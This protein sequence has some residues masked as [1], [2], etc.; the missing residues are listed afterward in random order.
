MKR[1]IAMI[2][3]F[4][5]SGYAIDINVF[6]NGVNFT[7]D[8][9]V[10]LQSSANGLWSI[11]QD[12]QDNRPTDFAYGNPTKI[13]KRADCI[14]AEGKVKTRTG[15]WTI[16][17]VYTRASDSIKCLRRFIYNGKDAAKVS[18]KNEFV[19]PTE[20]EKILIPSVIYYGNPS[21]FK[22]GANRVATF[23]KKDSKDVL[24]E[25]HRISMP[26]VCAEFS[27]GDKL[28]SVALHTIPTKA[29][30]SNKND[31]WWTLGASVQDG[32]TAL[33]S[34]SGAVAYNNK[35]GRVKSL[36]LQSHN[37]PDTYLNV[38]DGAIIQKTFYISAG[39]CDREG[40]GFMQAVDASLN[41][42]QPFS[43]YG[44]P[45]YSEIVKSKFKFA[46]S[47]YDEGAKHSGFLMFPK[48]FSKK[49]IVFGWCGQ[50]AAMGYAYQHLT[51]YGDSSEIQKRV[52]KS[53][54]FLTN[55]EFFDGGF[56]TRYDIVSDKW[57]DGDTLSQA[58]G[59]QNF[60]MAISSAKKSGK[61]DTTKWEIFT[62]KACDFHA[63]RVLNP[64]WNP[65]S[66]NEGFLGSPLALGYKIF[67]DSKLKEAALKVADYY[68]NR[69]L[70]MKESYWGGTL[71]AIGEDKE[72]AWAGLQAFL[73]AYD[74]TQDKKYLSYAKHA[75]YV[76]LT[77]TVVWNID[78]PS[79]R[80]SD[81]AF[82][83]LGW[84][85]VSPQNQHLDVYGVLYTPQ[86]YRLGKILNDQRLLRLSEVMF[87]TCG[88]LIDE[89]GSQ[90]EQIQQTNFSQWKVNLDSDVYAFRG[91]YAENWTV[92]WITAHFLNAAAQFEELGVSNF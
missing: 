15:V 47:R 4:A 42:F 21:G 68:A 29:S 81:N 70:S 19:I 52:Q 31:Q 66:T 3:M 87:R 88:Q 59:L 77:Y 82:K 25:E 43:T 49:H 2:G 9:E 86:L 12:W 33:I 39:K 74:I 38:R 17:D 61:Y 56:R 55:A 48:D 30:F 16:K 80:L 8:G 23:S 37:Y 75:A 67:N 53:L 11:A 46:Q 41:I 57:S 64:D 27:K 71:D 73:A 20:T 10:L 85:A 6:E 50:A 91:G 72:G 58:Q 1:Y 40:S 5:C 18:L 79:G 28:Y 83:T 84:T 60:L 35:W 69:H 45:S 7:E 34:T 78:M 44:M 32:S 90:G 13:E 26:F 65:V 14:I 62:K 54:D 22:H 63:K 36:Q 24:F 76:V 89:N 92:L 51:S